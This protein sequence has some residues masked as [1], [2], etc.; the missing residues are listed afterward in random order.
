MADRPKIR[1]R[2]KAKEEICR[3][4]TK[5][6]DQQPLNLCLRDVNELI[7]GVG[8][9]ERA[10]LP[11]P[12]MTNAEDIPAVISRSRRRKKRSA[13]FVPPEKLANE[14]CICKFK[15]VAGHQPRLQEKKV[16]SIDSGGNFKFFPEVTT[17]T[18]SQ[19]P[20]SLNNEETIDATAK[21]IPDLIPIETI[22]Q[23][24]QQQQ[25]QTTRTGD[26]PS[27]SSSRPAQARK[28]SKRQRLEQ[29]FKEKGFLIQT[30]HVQAN[31]QGSVFC[32]F[33]QLKKFTR[34]LYRSW[35][36]YLPEEQ[37]ATANSTSAQSPVVE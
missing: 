6:A 2:K 32:K 35:R 5:S 30:Q 27:T 31:T 18:S 7:V 13:I 37:P 9:S 19:Q 28:L 17:T 25:Q 3:L 11:D 10:S 1:S 8:C 29:T 24:Q 26:A 23:L 21:P 16:L 34:Y 4:L 33:R 14:V 12:V 15:F 20:N 22:L 36:N